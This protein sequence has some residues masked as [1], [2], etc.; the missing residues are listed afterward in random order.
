[1]GEALMHCGAEV[2]RVEDT[3]SRMG[4]AYGAIEMNVFVITTSIVVTMELSDGAHITLTRRL[5]SDASTDFRKLARINTLSRRFCREKMTVE[6]LEE[7]FIKAMKPTT[8]P[9]RLYIGSAL[10]AGSFAVFFGGNI[11]DGI[12]AAIFGLLICLFQRKLLPLAPNK[13]IYNIACSFIVGVGIC[14]I[15]RI[16][17]GLNSDKIIIGDIMLLIP[18]LAMTN[19]IRD[20]LVGDTVAGSMRFIESI[21][22]A[23]SLAIGFMS[24]IWLVGC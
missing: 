16:I 14:I 18:G 2:N 3:L 5:T 22:W 15:T 9:V 17:Q 10:A 19:A 1:M 4:V 11:F 20:I 23:G 12:V 24:A 21:I 6:A 8:K 7:E 13:V